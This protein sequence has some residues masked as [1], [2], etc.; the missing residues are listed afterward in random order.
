MNKY[1][2]D[3]KYGVYLI[4]HPFK[5][6]WDIKHELQVKSGVSVTLLFAF[7]FTRLLRLQF[8]GVLFRTNDP[9]NINFF[10]EILI[11]VAAYFIWCS[12]NWCLTTLM[13]GE[14]S[15]KDI[16]LATSYCLVPMIIMDIPLI[17]LSNYFS[18]REAQIFV[19]FSRLPDVWF[20]FLIILSVLV[21]HQYGLVKTMITMVLIFIGMGLII[22][23]ILLF[24]D[25]IQ[26]MLG[27]GM[28]FYKE[29]TY[30]L[31]G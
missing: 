12:A 26:Q 7:V 14:G 6:F 15:F 3:L 25:L 31:G 19:I 1:F 10:K 4:F 22:F 28:N 8:T 11:I 29:L 13:D 24:F 18:T 9:L 23:I 30:V 2:S 17:L 21:T 5:G 27:F 20:V 16:C